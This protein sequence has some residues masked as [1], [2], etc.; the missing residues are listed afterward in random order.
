MPYSQT[1]VVIGGIAH[2]PVLVGLIGLFD[3]LTS[4]KYYK[5]KAAK[6]AAEAKAKAKAK[7]EAEAKAKAAAEAAL[8]D[9]AEAEAKAEEEKNNGN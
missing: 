7:A 9:N 4:K 2:I 3:R 5:E 1:G 8:K 6:D